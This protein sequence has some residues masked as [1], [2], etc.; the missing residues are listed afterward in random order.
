MSHLF[1]FHLIPCL[2]G[3]SIVALLPLFPYMPLELLYSPEDHESEF[4]H[5]LVMFNL[6]YSATGSLKLLRN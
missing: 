5:V 4:L 2:E 6:D 3:A 1:W